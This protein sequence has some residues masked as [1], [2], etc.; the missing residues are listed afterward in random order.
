MQPE[1]NIAL[2]LRRAASRALSEVLAQ[3]ERR[4]GAG[5]HDLGLVALA[6]DGDLLVREVHV[7]G[8]DATQLA[9]AEGG[10]EEHTDDRGIAG[11]KEIAA[12]AGGQQAGEGVIGN[13]E[14]RLVLRHGQGHTLRR[15][16]VQAR[17]GFRRH[18]AEPKPQSQEPHAA[19]GFLEST[20]VGE[21]CKP[22]VN[23]LPGVI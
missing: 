10:V 22:A 4:L 19:G 9:A 1:R 14:H 23:V 17:V 11:V 15:V 3:R 21:V 20:F 6:G 8:V 2:R 18:V 5:R 16:A 7:V 12:A 13:D